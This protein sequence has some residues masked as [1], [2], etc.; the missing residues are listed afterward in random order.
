MKKRTIIILCTAAVVVAASVFMCSGP[1]SKKDIVYETKKVDRGQVAEYVTATGTIE[2]VTEVEV[3]TQVSGII[4]RIYVDFNSEVTKGMLIAEMDRITLQSELASARASYAGQ[5]A[6]YEYQKKTYERNKILHDKQLISDADFEQS[7]Y[8]YLQ[9]KASYE[10]S[11]A[12]V[13]RQERNLSYATITSPIDGVVISRA[14]EEG[15]T[16]ASGFNTPTLFTIAAD[17]TQMQVVADVDEADIGGIEEG[18]R[19]SFTVDAYPDD[20]FDGTIKQVRLG[21]STTETTSTVVTYEVIIAAPNPNLQLKPRMTANVKIFKKEKDNV[22]RVPAKAIRF[23]PIAGEILKGDVIK[24]KDSEQK[25]WTRE[26]N[27]LVAHPVEIGMN[28]GAYAEILS[29]IEEGTEVITDAVDKNYVLPDKTSP[30]MAAGA[31]GHQR[32]NGGG[33]GGPGGPR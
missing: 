24:D 11:Q 7:E 23:V 14:V 18:Q 31:E 15:Q 16:V 10:S 2:P 6:S 30:M 27:Q 8:N 20:V 5:K 12:D 33:P 13:A 32:G 21:Q 22:V 25:V 26:G 1:A 29:G 3:G 19:A 28:D 4:D 9:S 17:L